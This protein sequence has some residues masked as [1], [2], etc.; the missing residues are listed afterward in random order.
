MSHVKSRAES[1]Q[2]TVVEQWADCL[3]DL[4]EI[5][6]LLRLER[7]R[8]ILESYTQAAVTTT[9]DMARPEKHTPNGENKPNKIVAPTDGPGVPMYSMGSHR[10]LCRRIDRIMNRIVRGDSYSRSLPKLC[11]QRSL[12]SGAVNETSSLR[13]MVRTIMSRK[14]DVTVLSTAVAEDQDRVLSPSGF[15]LCDRDVPRNVPKISAQTRSLLPDAVGSSRV[16]GHMQTIPVISGERNLRPHVF[17]VQPYSEPME[18]STPGRSNAKPRFHRWDGGRL[19]Y[20]APRT[21]VCYGAQTLLRK[22]FHPLIMQHCLAE[23]S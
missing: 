16:L 17:I 9:N 3:R 15:N 13:S 11:K 6:G 10:R 5:A 7:R 20:T 23:G 1:Y 21:F 4:K 2:N 19:A 22:S 18:D 12:Q 14:A 8:R